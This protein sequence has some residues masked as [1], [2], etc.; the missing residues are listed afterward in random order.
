LFYFTRLVIKIFEGG[1]YDPMIPAA[2]SRKYNVA[3][4]DIYGITTCDMNFSFSFID[5]L[6]NGTTAIHSNENKEHP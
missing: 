1:C 3:I 2:P 4:N 5:F 6:I